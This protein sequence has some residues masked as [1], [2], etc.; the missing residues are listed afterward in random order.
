MEKLKKQKEMEWQE[1]LEEQQESIR[2]HLHAQ[3]MKAS[4]DEDARIGKM[5]E[6]QHA[7]REVRHSLQYG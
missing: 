4:Q 1:Q 5:V 2:D 7:K 6:E 3:M